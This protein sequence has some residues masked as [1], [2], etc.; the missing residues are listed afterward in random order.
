M[1][2]PGRLLR[3]LRGFLFGLFVCF[4]PPLSAQTAPHP[5]FRQY[6]TD[7]GLSSSEIY[8]ILQDREGYIWISSDNG[9]SRFDGYGFRNYSVKDGL[10]ENVIFQMQPDT[11]GRVWMQAMG[12]NL[13]YLEG[14]TILPYWNNH[15]LKQFKG[16]S[17]V[18]PGFIVEG[19]GETVHVAA[20]GY[21]ILSISRDGAVKTYS[22][23]EPESFQVF[24]KNGRAIISAN[25][26]KSELESFRLHQGKSRDKNYSI[27]V[28]F[29]MPGAVWS[30]PEI[31]Y[32]RIGKQFEAFLLAPGQYFLKI[33]DEI[34]Y[35]KN[36][37]VQWQH[38][39]P[40]V[41]DHACL[42]ANGQLWLGLYGQQGLKI[43]PSV[44]AFRNAGASA[45][46]PGESVSYFLEDREGGIWIATNKNGVFYT[47]ADAL[48][49][50]DK[51]TGLPDENVTALSIKNDRALFIGLGNGNIWQLDWQ[52]ETW[53]QLPSLF[54]AHEFIQDLHYDR[55]TNR[56]WAANS[57]LYFFQQD[58]WL[59]KDVKYHGQQLSFGKRITESPD[60]KRL[61]VS[62][63]IGFMGLDL[64]QAAPENTRIGYDQ[65][66]YIVQE[67][68]AGR[69]W[70][71]RPKGLFEWKNDALEER[72]ILHPAFSLRVEDIALMPDSSLV[73]ATKGGGIVFWKDAQFE[74]LTTD[75]GLCADMLECLHVDAQGV[76]WA[77]TLNGLN[78]ISGSWGKRRVGQITVSHGLPSNE[79]NRIRTSGTTVWVATSKGLAR[80]S[81]KKYNPFS[82][83]PILESVLAN[84]R[85]VDL[86][87]AVRLRPNQNNL[88]IN[89][90]ALNFK[91]NGQ[92]RYR[93]R[94]DG[95]PWTQTPNRAVN[96]AELP[97]GKRLFEVQAQNEDGVWSE[98]TALGFLIEP[99]WWATWWA[100]SGAFIAAFLLIF[101]LYKFRT[102]QLK[103]ENKIQRQM[104]ELERA[105]LQ[106][107][108]NPHFIF[109]CLNSIQNFILQNEKEAAIL[110]LGRFASL[111]RSTLNASVAGKIMLEEEVQLLNNYLE[112]EKLRFKNRFSFTVEIAEDLDRF[113]TMIPPLLV[114]PYVEN[115]VLHGISGRTSGGIVSV[116]FSKKAN[117][118]V[119]SIQDNGAGPDPANTR[120][121]SPKT[122]KSFGMTITKKRL[123]LLAAG[124]EKSRVNIKTRYDENGGVAGTEVIIC[125]ELPHTN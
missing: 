85:A 125:I 43:Y 6:N 54:P 61:W 69:V 52:Q 66:T 36:G 44:E 14:D 103:K 47:P 23:D 100:R 71:G 28:Y 51:G 53:N 118:L 101:G 17:D 81:S 112:L 96:Y 107:Q 25:L 67:D 41:I 110:Y 39:F 45:W 27:P 11:S 105:A 87:Q 121:S 20:W 46:L 91:M 77:G 113:E 68:Y 119:V 73:I 109:N 99:P 88:S 35:V 90:L 5:A 30:F 29:Y 98:S 74:Q 1:V 38:H 19:A 83:R 93:Y 64:P 49:V 2:C 37:N 24:E 120:D 104:A 86:S 117:W 60:G 42:M 10:L 21:G 78:R 9:V 123:E 111:I 58:R 31:F 116:L 114:Q 7:T 57:I 18:Y 56:F 15:I 63:H 76:V 13:Y 48:R 55:Q 106:A 94:M 70:V 72:Q 75:Q 108:M 40:Q 115:A 59:R 122:H 89:F 95:G 12:G 22:H 4:T 82:P 34:W 97:P 84:N 8:C 32:S 50:Y 79:I 62:G 102:G 124:K 26:I 33:A 3:S 92:I 65:R 80:F 16:G